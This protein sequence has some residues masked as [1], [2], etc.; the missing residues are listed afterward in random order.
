M[1]VDPTTGIPSVNRQIAAIGPDCYY[2]HCVGSHKS[3][4]VVV[5]AGVTVN[6][7]SKVGSIKVYIG[8]HLYPFKQ[9]VELFV[10][11]VIG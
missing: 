3:G 9:E 1:P 4:D 6:L 5:K 10:V 11:L 8:I 7:F 2:I